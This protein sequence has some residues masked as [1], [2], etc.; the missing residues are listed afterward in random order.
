MNTIGFKYFLF[1]LTPAQAD[2][3]WP[4]YTAQGQDYLEVN[5]L[6]LRR[7][8][9]DKN[10]TFWL[11]LLPRLSSIIE[12]EVTEAPVSDETASEVYSTLTWLLLATVLLLLVLLA[13]SWV[14]AR[15]RARTES[16]FTLGS[17][18]GDSCLE[19]RGPRPGSGPRSRWRETL[20]SHRM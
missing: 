10:A 11:E 19:S 6:R 1:I 17:G 2:L 14:T 13:V 18:L 9:K 20:T 15:R 12:T 8:Y 16:V 7:G 4:R 3:R 5:T